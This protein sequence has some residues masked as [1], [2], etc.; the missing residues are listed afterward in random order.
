MAKGTK[1]CKVCGKEYEYCKTWRPS[2]VF[3]YQD[4]ACSK[5]CGDIYFAKIMKS[6]G[7]IDKD[8]TVEESIGVEEQC[9]VA[10]D[11]SIDDSGEM[12]SADET[13]EFYNE[14]GQKEERKNEDENDSLDNYF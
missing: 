4:V 2:E 5:E 11:T 14:D 12:L 7:L 13:F 9:S 1:I 3:R 10:D 8:N 6:R